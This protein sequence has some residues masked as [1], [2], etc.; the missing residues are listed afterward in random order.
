MKPRKKIA[1]ALMNLEANCQEQ[2]LRDGSS[3]IAIIH[4]CVKHT[5]AVCYV[6]LGLRWVID[7]SL[8]LNRIIMML[9]WET[10]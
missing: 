7:E 1:G 2:D 6:L 10:A 9:R 3:L 5:L 8:L 4:G